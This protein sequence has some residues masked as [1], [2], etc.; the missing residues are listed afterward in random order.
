MI[1]QPRDDRVAAHDLKGRRA[2]V[3][4]ACTMEE[5]RCLMRHKQYHLEPLNVAEGAGG[6]RAS[7]IPG[8]PTSLD[9][10]KRSERVKVI[11]KHSQKDTWSISVLCPIMLVSLHEGMPC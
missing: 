5:K 2:L 1:S 10:P 4:H 3:S 11:A 6:T 8:M 9:S 7:V